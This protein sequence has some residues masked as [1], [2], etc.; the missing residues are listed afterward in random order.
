ML[1]HRRLRE[2]QI[3]RLLEGAP[4]QVSAMVER[5]YVGVDP[6]LRPAAE[7]SVLAHLLDLSARGLVAQD[8][9]DWR[10]PA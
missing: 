6:R 5:M 2:G 10:I 4:S 9:P 8:G 7:R 1:G 3:L